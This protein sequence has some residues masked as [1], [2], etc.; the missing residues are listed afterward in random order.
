MLRYLKGVRASLPRVTAPLLVM[1]SPNDHTA[2]PSNATVVMNGV[3]SS[4]KELVWLERSYHVLTL[5][6]DQDEV[7]TRAQRFI[8]DRTRAGATSDGN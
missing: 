3:S 2:H 7:F 1:H 5:D 6:N 4:D 8:A